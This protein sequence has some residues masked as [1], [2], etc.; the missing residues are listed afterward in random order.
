MYNNIVNEYIYICETQKKEERDRKKMK[1]KEDMKVNF[2]I[3]KK[4][5]NREIIMYNHK[6]F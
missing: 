5:R 4:F 3:I 6:H 1:T 2:V